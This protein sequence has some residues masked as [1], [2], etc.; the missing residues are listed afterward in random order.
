MCLSKINDFCRIV[1][2]KYVALRERIKNEDGSKT[3]FWLGFKAKATL[4]VLIAFVFLFIILSLG[5]YG[6]AKNVEASSISYMGIIIV[7]SRIVIFL[8][9]LKI[10]NL[11]STDESIDKAMVALIASDIFVF[12]FFSF[13]LGPLGSFQSL[14][15]KEFFGTTFWIVFSALIPVWLILLSV[16]SARS[17]RREMEVIYG[18]QP[19]LGSFGTFFMS[20][21]FSG[22]IIV[23]SRGSWGRELAS[24]FFIRDIFLIYLLLVFCISVGRVGF[25]IFETTINISELDL[26]ISRIKNGQRVYL[27]GEYSRLK[28]DSENKNLFYGYNIKDKKLYYEITN[29]RKK[30]LVYA[31]N[32]FGK[33][34]SSDNNRV[35]HGAKVEVWGKV[36]KINR[37]GNNFD[38]I[39]PYRISVLGYPNLRRR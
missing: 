6:F 26:P 9:I 32:N 17:S 30:Y 35:S 39:F 13:S 2:G 25:K 22:F 21:I 36:V 27:I 4:A 14:F 33:L 31:G 29:N 28:I 34:I 15:P 19:G 37:D 18:R 24:A 8:G 16:W 11:K 5:L 12:L 7:F 23:G 1:N 20:I 38:Y 3:R 10:V